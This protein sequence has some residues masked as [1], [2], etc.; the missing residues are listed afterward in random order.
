MKKKK[1]V[2][3][4]WVNKMLKE[5]TFSSYK[6][7]IIILH[8][9]QFIRSLSPFLIVSTLNPA[10]TIVLILGFTYKVLKILIL[11]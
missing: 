1:K 8:K 7:W 11:Y 5:E 6:D 4:S 3:T 9:E 10:M 2:I